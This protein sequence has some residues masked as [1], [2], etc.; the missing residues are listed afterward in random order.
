MKANKDK[1]FLVI[2]EEEDE[3]PGY[4]LVSISNAKIGIVF[5]IFSP[6]VT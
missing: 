2:S 1:S 3:M 5:C 4:N 6:C